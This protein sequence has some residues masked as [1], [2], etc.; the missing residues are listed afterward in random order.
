MSTTLVAI[1]IYIIAQLTIGAW[2]SRRIRTEADYILAGRSLGYGLAVFTIFATWFGAETCIGA[3]GAVYENG[4]TGGS[5]DPFGYTLCLVL[6][7]AF[8]AVPLWR[9]KLTTMADLFRSRYSINV[10]R[11]AVLLMV[12]TSLLWGAAQIRAFGQVISASSSLEVSITITIAAA[13]VVIYTMSGGLLA[14]AI[15]DLVQGIA[16]IIG[17]VILLIAVLAN[18]GIEAARAIDPAKLQLFG[19]GDVP[20]IEVVESWAIP[21]FGSVVAAEL[22][23]RVIAARSPAVAQRSCFIASGMYLAVGLIPVV[24]GLIGAQLITGLEDPEQILARL[25]LERLSP[26]LYAIFAGAL[27]SA[28]LSTVDTTLLVSASMVS[29]NLIL[30]LRP[31]LSEAQKV[32]T[33]RIGVL[34]FGII[35]Y[36]MAISAEG[37]YALVEQASAFGSAG[38]FVIVVFGL[39]TS[40]GGAGSAIAA[41]LVGVAVWVVGSYVLALPYAYIAALLSATA[42]YVLVALVERFTGRSSSAATASSMAAADAAAWPRRPQRF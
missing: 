21:V 38:I 27:I 32:R 11:L 40:L 17:L 23:S 41:L 34:V 5:A 2:V 42:A 1:T 30:P 8:F 9:R 10:E 6:M 15:T 37:V 29:H 16:L 36:G 18:G 12:P 20:W 13:V 26:V 22:I 7:G 25:A 31:G 39:F 24:L 14:D 3:A 19:G 4:L 28:I 33:A 35:A